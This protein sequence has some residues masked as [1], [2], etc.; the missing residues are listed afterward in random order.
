[1][2][3]LLAVLLAASLAVAGVLVSSDTRSAR[4]DV[5]PA[6]AGLATDGELAWWSRAA[7]DLLCRASV[8]RGADSGYIAMF[9]HRGVPIHSYTCG[10][11]DL[12]SGAPLTLDTE[13]RIASMTKPIT[14]VAAMTLVE[15]GRLGL[16]D[17]V[18]RYLPEFSNPRVATSNVPGPD[19]EFP[20]RPADNPLLIRHLLMF[21]SGIGPGREEGSA[22]VEHWRE[23]GI[24]RAASGDLRQ[25]VRALAAL[26]LLEEPG[27]KWR[28]GFS[29][30]VLGAVLEEI[31]GQPLA[32]IMQQRIFQPL[33][34]DSTRFL[35]PTD[36]RAAMASVYTVDSEGDLVPAT[37]PFDNDGWTPGG[38]GLV[39]TAGD[40]MR[41]ALMLYNGGEYQGARILQR[42]TVDNMRRL[43]VPNGVL[44]AEG[45]DGL[46]W[47]LGMAV[48]ADA[49]AS[50]IPDR[51]GD[52]WWSG[53]YGTTFSISPETDLVSV[54]LSQCE[55]SEFGGLPV[56]LYI[57][58]G[59]ALEGI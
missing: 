59:I 12:A 36:E 39:S 41:F 1:M 44:A 57:I 43:H 24:Y 50:M 33:G 40:Y 38:G 53:Y 11:K 14:A 3:I 30:D 29:L 4:L 8:W 47:G 54:V 17:P 31:T 52:F 26:P 32:D 58:Q 13:V 25:R 28:Y 48:V 9:A 45:I 23:K 6:A 5:P 35:P 18:A 2:K 27:T 10:Y 55:P 19:G 22:L 56:E 7:I 37:L 51:N 42:E 15:E 16:D 21:A 49:E 20:S 46:G 34:M